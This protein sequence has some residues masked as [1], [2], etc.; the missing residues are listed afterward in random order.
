VGHIKPEQATNQ[1]FAALD[2]VPTLVD[3]AG[4]PKGDALKKQIEAGSCPG[5]LK[6]T[7]DGFDQKDFLEGNTEHSARNVMFFYS[8][9]DLS[10]LRY[11][12]LKFYYKTSQPGGNGWF[13]PLIDYHFT[14]MT[15]LKRDPFEQNVTPWDSKSVAMAMGR[16]RYR[17]R[18]TCRHKTAWLARC[19]R[20][21]GIRALPFAQC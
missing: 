10:A 19:A 5:I 20:P 1:M 12:N 3:I 13:L 9:A 8:G 14:T 17:P 21:S 2:W 4:E 16:L 6:T 7:L 15:D 18:S 11:R